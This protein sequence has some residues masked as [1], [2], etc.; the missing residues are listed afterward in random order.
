MAADTEGPIRISFRLGRV[1]VTRAF[2]ISALVCHSATCGGVTTVSE[3][4]SAIWWREMVEFFDAPTTLDF[5]RKRMLLPPKEPAHV[6]QRTRLD[7][8]RD[9]L[10]RPL[11]AA[12]NGKEPAPRAPGN[13][14]M[15]DAQ[16]TA[17]QSPSY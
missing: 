16:A 2:L 12:I 5:R 15:V 7:W 1:R 10:H 4:F 11:G 17:R 14:K 13:Q 6:K 9:R 8:S 3:R